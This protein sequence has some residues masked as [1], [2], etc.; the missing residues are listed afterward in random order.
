MTERWLRFC[1]AFVILSASGWIIGQRLSPPP[2]PPN[3]QN[4]RNIYNSG[5]I[6]CHGSAGKGAPET[7]TEFKRPDTFPDFSRC[8]QTTPET[9]IQYKAAI[10]HGGPYRGLSTIM[11]AFGQLLSDSDINDVVAYLRT[12][13]TERHWPR[14][15]LNLPRA[16]VTEKAFPENELVLSSEASASGAPSWTMHAIHEQTFGKRDQVE[17]DM[18]WD[19]ENINHSYSSH[20]G[21]MTFGLKHVLFSDLRRGSILSL[22]G[23]VIPP[24]GSQK[25]GGNG[26]TVFE[27]FAAFDQ[28]F[29]TN[30]WVQFQMGADLPRH[31]DITPQSLFWYTALGQT[32]ARDHRLGRQ[33]SPMVEFL[34]NR[35]LKDGAKT[36]WD[37]LPEMQV[38]LSP[39]QH[40]R[41]DM[42]VR[43][44]FTDTAGRSPQVN[45]YILW[46]WADGRFWEGW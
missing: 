28:L 30:T 39:R 38:T 2:Q 15:E 36:D 44:P 46:D 37:V 14:G 40:I 31:P 5:C 12:F 32:W 4:G 3:V 43:M 26:T 45:F 27:P 16:L 6:V 1:I 24:T 10:V 25:L 22:Q 20:I 35:D 17:I 29:V 41:A 42:G 8:D 9:N 11:P 18:P 19:L 33:W 13:C 21:D 23:G 7:N 34:A